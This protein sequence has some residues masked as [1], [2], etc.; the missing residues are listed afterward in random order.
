MQ[1]SKPFLLILVAVLVAIK[2]ILVPWYFFQEEQIATIEVNNKKLSRVLVLQGQQQALEEQYQKLSI[3][4][5]TYEKSLPNGP[6]KNAVS[7]TVQSQW[8]EIFEQHQVEVK[9]F[10][11]TGERQLEQSKFWVA[12]VVIKLSAPL[13]KNIM[14]LAELVK[15]YPAVSFEESIAN[16]A[17]GVRFQQLQE[18]QLTIDVLFKVDAS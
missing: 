18:V 15:K 17:T 12:R 9:L 16:N 13:E 7:L 1:L 8:Q 14:A 10:N 11:W 6:D 5:T 2:F 3:I 4:L